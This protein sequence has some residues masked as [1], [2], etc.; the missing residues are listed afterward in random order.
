MNGAVNIKKL[1]LGVELRWDLCIVY[2]VL[3]HDGGAHGIAPRRGRL[4][5][6]GLR[7]C[8]LLGGWRS[9][10]LIAGLGNW[11]GGRRAL[12]HSGARHL[13]L[14]PLNLLGTKVV[15]AAIRQEETVVL[16]HAVVL[17]H[18]SL[19]DLLGL[20]LL[21]HGVHSVDVLADGGNL[22]GERGVLG[23]GVRDEVGRNL[24]LDKQGKEL[25]RELD[26]LG[27]AVVGQF[28]ELLQLG[29]D[30]HDADPEEGALELHGAERLGEPLLLRR[31]R[32]NSVAEL[33]GRRDLLKHERDFEV[34]LV[35]HNDGVG[36][37]EEVGPRDAADHH[38]KAAKLA[39]P[40]D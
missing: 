31:E 16:R 14:L 20:G 37:L 5:G 39:G 1:V 30:L 38:N 15:K 11:L 40:C 8:R 7:H 18:L 22:L 9:G 28:E 26:L 32:L 34:I 6:P 27:E 10:H 36:G 19:F 24:V 2:G 13:L 4:L 23:A 25:L 35:L 12:S 21:D 29:L 33:L 17:A 3:W